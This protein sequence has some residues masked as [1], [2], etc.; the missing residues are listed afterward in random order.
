MSKVFVEKSADE[1]ALDG[2]SICPLSRALIY[3]PPFNSDQSYEKYYL[4]I[5]GNVKLEVIYIRLGLR[6]WGRVGTDD[7]IDRN[8]VKKLKWDLLELD[9]QEFWEKYSNH[10]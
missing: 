7:L 2:W 8:Y 9:T 3:K 4:E 6:M 5:L 1:Y 10:K